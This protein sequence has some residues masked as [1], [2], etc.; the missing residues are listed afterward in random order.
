MTAKDGVQISTVSVTPYLCAGFPDFIERLA[1]GQRAKETHQVF[2]NHSG[3][4]ELNTDFEHPLAY[5]CEWFRSGN[6]VEGVTSVL[7][8]PSLCE[9]DMN[10][11]LLMS[12]HIWNQTIN[13]APEVCWAQL[14]AADKGHAVLTLTAPLGSATIAINLDHCLDGDIFPVNLSQSTE[15]PCQLTVTAMVD[16]SRNG[17]A[18]RLTFAKGSWNIRSLDPSKG[19]REAGSLSL[20]VSAGDNVLSVTGDYD[21]PITRVP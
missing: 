10:S 19:G 18:S 16:D 6:R 5:R 14:T 12:G 2:I 11:T 7:A 1:S 13:A 9:G 3:E 4:L 21:L 8:A 20:Y 17:T 15:R